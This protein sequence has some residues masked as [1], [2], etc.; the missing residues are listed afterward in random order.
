MTLGAAFIYHITTESEAVLASTLGE[1]SPQAFDADGFIHCSYIHQVP[2][3]ANARFH[4]RT[5]LVLLKIDQS[6][7]P[8]PI[9]DENLEGGLELFPH[10]YGR[11]PM[12][13]VSEI[14]PF[15][16]DADGRFKIPDD[17]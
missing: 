2:V 6:K 15:P 13:A 5:D 1:Y 7:V 3:V 10:I 11:L 17:M 12:T 14:Q 16:C 8:S 9:V 4:G